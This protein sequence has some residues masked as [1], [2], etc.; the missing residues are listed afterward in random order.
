MNRE[1]RAQEARFLERVALY[2]KEYRTDRSIIA[3]AE[4]E[5]RHANHEVYFERC[6][7]P[8]SEAGRVVQGFQRKELVT[9]FEVIV[10][11]AVLLAVAEGLC[12]LFAF[13]F[14]P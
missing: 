3:A 12:T 5:R 1:M 2:R 13:L 6:W 8:E 7:I 9:F 14:L 10:L 11:L 4:R